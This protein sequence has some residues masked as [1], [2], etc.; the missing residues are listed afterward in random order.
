M[1]DASRSPRPLWRRALTLFIVTA[2]VAV[3]AWAIWVKELHHPAPHIGTF[4]SPTLAIGTAV[5]VS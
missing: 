1:I 4:S 2:L 3:F 5:P